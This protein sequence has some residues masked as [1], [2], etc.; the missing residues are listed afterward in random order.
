LG[1]V[2]DTLVRRLNGCWDIRIRRWRA[3]P[4]RFAL[5]DRLAHPFTS[6]TALVF[7]FTVYLS[8]RRPDEVLRRLEMAEALA[9]EQ[10]LTFFIE[11]E[12]LR[13]AAMVELEFMHEGTDLIRQGLTRTRQRGG[14][15]F[16]PFGLAFLADGL[17]RR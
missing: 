8:D 13:G 1:P 9:A 5:A 12:I 17:N 14:T 2:P 6:I 16:M 7:G 15:F 4:R 11:P 3:L 10:R